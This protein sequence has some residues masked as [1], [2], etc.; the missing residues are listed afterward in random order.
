MRSPA[1]YSDLYVHTSLGRGLDAPHDVVEEAVKRG[2]CAIGLVEGAP[3]AAAAAHGK[4]V[5]KALQRDYS[6]DIRI[7]HG[8]ELD[9]ADTI[10]D[11]PYDY[12][13]GALHTLRFG[14]FRCPIGE[15]AEALGKIIQ[16]HCAGDGYR[17]VREYYRQMCELEERT[18][19]DVVAGFDLIT[20]HNRNDLYFEERDPRYLSAAIE[21]LELLLQRD[22]IF[23]LQTG[24]MCYAHRRLPYP[25]PVLLRYIAQ[26]GGRIT[27]TSGALTKA[28]LGYAFDDAVQ[29]ARSCGFGSI[30]TMTADGWKC[31]GI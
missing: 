14:D 27:L 5:I 26:K 1:S 11:E 23:A 3:T 6:A 2:L 12:I 15:G 13:I 30:L 25:S 28:E 17:L 21:A 24:D 22:V 9:P 16:A 29:L 8:V 10:P 20:K 18:Q 7:L 4:A 19:C 31:R